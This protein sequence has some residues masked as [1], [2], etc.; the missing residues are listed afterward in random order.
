MI[1]FTFVTEFDTV[2]TGIVELL[3]FVAAI[4]VSGNRLGSVSNAISASDVDR[5]IFGIPYLPFTFKKLFIAKC[6]DRVEVSRFTRGI[7][8]KDDADYK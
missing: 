5:D 4:A 3:A 8:T 6:I 1:E 7:D 2:M